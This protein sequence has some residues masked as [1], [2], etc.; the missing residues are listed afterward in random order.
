MRITF[1][2]TNLQQS[3]HRKSK[4]NTPIVKFIES[5]ILAIICQSAPE[6]VARSGD[7]YLTRNRTQTRLQCALTEAAAAA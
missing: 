2:T 4:L 7:S 3:S 1:V 5:H 6:A